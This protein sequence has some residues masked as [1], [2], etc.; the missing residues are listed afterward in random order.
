M[1]WDWGWLWGDSGTDAD[2]LMAGNIREEDA[3]N[4]MGS[5]AR[6]N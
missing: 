3:S 5:N 2:V 6:V 1:S 4:V